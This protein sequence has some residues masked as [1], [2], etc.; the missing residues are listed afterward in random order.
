M[1]MWTRYELKMRGK[2]AFKA[3][4]I[5]CVIVALILVVV[6]NTGSVSSVSSVIRHGGENSLEFL[7]M[8]YGFFT[9]VGTL[10]VLGLAS[11][12]G[13]GGILLKFF[14]FNPMEVNCRR[15]F[16]ANSYAP[17]GLNDLKYSFSEGRYSAVVKTMFFR[18]LFVFLWSLLFVIPGIV[19]SYQYRM[20][21]YIL[22]EDPF[23][24]HRA[25]LELSR[26]MMNGQKW[27][28]FVL[29]ISFIGWQI[30]SVLTAGILGIFYVNPYIYATEAELYRVLREGYV[31]AE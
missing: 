14:I 16:F 24:D 6:T 17:S 8:Y 21:P 9:L 31:R 2:V 7:N 3:N 27:D 20:L 12:V 11:I 25:A 26:S 23:I 1:I 22:S 5:F 13:I 30:L 28:S 18:D 15:F 19:K 29:D 4:F 10:I